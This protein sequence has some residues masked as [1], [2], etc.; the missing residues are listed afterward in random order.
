MFKRLT[1]LSIMILVLLSLSVP[2]FADVN[3]YL[4]ANDKTAIENALKEA[5]KAIGSD[6]SIELK[7]R[8]AE[9]GGEKE[10]TLFKYD[11]GAN[12][13]VFFEDNF[14]KSNQKELKKVMTA[15]INSIKD[16]TLSNDSQ[17]YIMTQLQESNR[18]V[19]A[20]LLPM[21]LDSTTADLFTAYKWLY[22]FLQI[23]RVIIGIGVV[24]IIL[25]LVG[26]TIMDL[27]YIGLPV[28][29]ETVAEKGQTT[30]KSH[31]FG[32]SYE[33]LCTVKQVEQA[34]EGNGYKN[35]VLIYFKR[36][37]ITYVTLSICLLY[38]IVGELGGLISWLLS[39]G[40]GVL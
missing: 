9:K 14:S 25:L 3:I 27:C 19:A 21:I 20:M 35:A 30:G 15:F 26:S 23:L 28:W 12:M 17:Q 1:A 38:L 22:P 4:N 33:A 10:V 2:V 11:D 6:N 34:L 31:P 18:D 7:V 39:L 36:R 29:R 16:S 40:S 32:V 13:L 37:A 24:G 8:N 5:N